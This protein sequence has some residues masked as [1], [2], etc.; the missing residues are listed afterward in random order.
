MGI[1]FQEIVN[2]D[3]DY[4]HQAIQIYDEAFPSNEKQSLD[5]IKNRVLER[6]SKLVV[7]II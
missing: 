3:E 1:E 5:I 7:G 2:V 6:K 4:F